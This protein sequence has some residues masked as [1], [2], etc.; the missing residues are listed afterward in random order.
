MKN[1]CWIGLGEGKGKGLKCYGWIIEGSDPLNRLYI[2]ADFGTRL[3]WPIA[4]FGVRRGCLSRVGKKKKKRR[5]DIEPAGIYIVK[6]RA[7]LL[8]GIV[9]KTV[10]MVSLNGR[11]GI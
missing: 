8:L 6:K 9:S 10:E 4:V 11:G 1:E 5:C 2:L 3:K 7:V